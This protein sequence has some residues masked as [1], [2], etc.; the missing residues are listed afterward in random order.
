M[1]VE[2]CLW[3]GLDFEY[4]LLVVQFNKCDLL[5]VVLEEEIC[6]CWLVV[7]W[8]LI[9]VLVL[10]GEGVVVSFEVLLWVIYCCFNESCE[11]DICYGFDEEVLV[12]GVFGKL[13]C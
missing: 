8:L 12:V 6:E 7:L 1:L 9:F 13:I 5:S 10:K 3:V 2:N 11:L 4:L